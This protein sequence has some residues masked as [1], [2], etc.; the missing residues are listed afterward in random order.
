LDKARIAIENRH[1]TREI[2]QEAVNCRFRGRAESRKGSRK[3]TSEKPVSGAI[4]L[5][6]DAV[7]KAQKPRLVPLVP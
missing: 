3:K 4:P 5:F 1:H 6:I 2:L 7:F